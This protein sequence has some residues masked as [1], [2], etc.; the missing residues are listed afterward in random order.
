MKA[1]LP[2]A[3]EGMFTSP[4]LVVSIVCFS[5]MSHKD[6]TWTCS[7]T[8]V[9]EPAWQADIKEHNAASIS[10]IVVED[11]LEREFGVVRRSP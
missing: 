8:D 4:N 2:G 10:C 6:H 1:F 5:R 7:I 3:A 11:E 9:H